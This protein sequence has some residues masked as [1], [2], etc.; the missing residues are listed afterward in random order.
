MPPEIIRL[1][2]TDSTNE[3]VFRR[4]PDHAGDVI[5][6]TAESQSA[7][8]GRAGRI[9]RSPPGNLYLSCGLKEPAPA[10]LLPQ[11]GF[12][13][14]AALAKALKTLAPHSPF[15]LKWPNDLLEGK[16]KLAGLLL[17]SRRISGH[18]CVA[19]GWGV[20]ISHFP[21][22][23]PYPATALKETHPQLNI[24]SVTDMLMKNFETMLALWERGKNFA[25]IRTE[26]LAH[27]LPK[28]TIMS[29]KTDASNIVHGIFESIDLDGALL[30]STPDGLLRVLAGDVMLPQSPAKAV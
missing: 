4:L 13:A 11:L 5:Y 1:E 20:N 18:S 19:V 30:L 9:W 3:D 24:E 28:G 12:V 25:T 10:P 23:L 21:K 6:I 16:A 8:R 26:W 29:V 15:F 27:A 17:E 14:G 7:G 2:T 22:D